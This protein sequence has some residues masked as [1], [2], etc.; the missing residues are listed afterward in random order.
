MSLPARIDEALLK[1]LT[2][3]VASSG[4]DTY[5]MTEVYTGEVIT[6]LPQSSAEDIAG[7][8]AEARSAQ[9][10]WA[11]WPVAKR[12][13]VFKKFHELLLERND[14]IVD[15]I[16]AESGKARRMAFEE[17]CDVPMVIS[18][19][20]RRA[21]K[22]LRPVKRGGPVPV[23]T[24]STEIRQPK[25]VV[26]IIAPW[27]FPFATGLS[28]AVPAL[29]AGNGVVLKP[30]NKTAL[31]PLYGVSL[32]YEAG[33]PRGLFQVVCGEGPV[34][35][36]PVVDHANFVMFTG[37]TQ[38]GRFIGKRA[39][40]NLVGA[41]LELGGKN[42]MVVLDDADLDEAIPGAIEGVFRN[43]GQVCMHIERI[44]VPEQMFE[45]YTRRFVAAAQKIKLGAAY[46]F[47]PE[48]GSLIS[49]D[50][51][52]RVAS[53]VEDARA[54][55]ATVLTGGRARPDIG[56]AFYEPTVLTGV[57]KQMLAG[58][59]ETFG[60][61]VALHPYR[62]LSEAIALANDTDYGLNAS[63]WGGDLR[64]ATEVARQL[65]AGNVNVNEGFA[66]AYASKGTPSGGVK[67]SGVGARHGDNGLLK[68]TD[69]Q[70]L[71]VVKKQVMGVQPGQSYADYAR[72]TLKSLAIMR[73]TGIR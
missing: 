65:H 54:K 7:A 35:G 38:T 31:S 16:Q 71:A 36:P 5:K 6:A 22:L 24:T 42:P 27:N 37:S 50:H 14:T 66:A 70:N 55:G 57:T 63:V 69:V 73:K 59:C 8:F 40:E 64:R 46:D 58:S 20:L 68:Y 3:L 32:L 39:G 41:T 67:Q 62:T 34:A 21:P 4:G 33:L 9:S 19:Y 47:E 49:V 60:P 26:G 17:T 11:S 44:Y 25:G 61:V 23:V 15:L 13:K 56:P 2:D 12:M 1:R 53:H 52:D 29:M 28:D 45:E 43:T 51:K 48:M 30:D 72:T 10:E 18:H